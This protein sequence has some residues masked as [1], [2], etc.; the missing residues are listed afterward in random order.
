MSMSAGVRILAVDDEDYM[1]DLYRVALDD[2]KPDSSARALD[3]LISLYEGE[4][5]EEGTGPTDPAT[6]GYR[7]DHASQGMEGYQRVLEARQQG[8]PYAVVLL[9]IQMP[10]G[11]DGVETA[12]KIRQ[13]DPQVR[14]LLVTAFTYY[15]YQQIQQ[16]LGT[17][18][19]LINKPFKGEALTRLVELEVDKWRAARSV[20]QAQRTL[21]EAEGELDQ[22]LSR[23]RKIQSRVSA[24]V[25]ADSELLLQKAQYELILDSIQEGVLV[26]DRTG[27]VEY[28]NPG[29]GRM[30]GKAV[31]DL[32]GQPLAQLFVEGKG[33]QTAEPTLGQ[34]GRVQQFLQQ[35]AI[36]QPPLL[37]SWID[38]SLVAVLRINARGKVVQSNAAMQALSGWTV[39]QLEGNPIDL[40]P[41]DIREQ[42]AQM[43]QQFIQQGEARRMGG[44]SGLFEIHTRTRK[45]RRVMI[46]LIPLQYEG[47][48]QVVVVLHDPDEQ[49]QWRLFQL[50]PFGR[51]FSEDEQT[52]FSTSMAMHHHN[53]ELIPVHVTGAPLYHCEGDRQQFF[54]VVLMLHNAASILHAEEQQRLQQAKDR[55]LSTVSHELR[56]PLTGIIGNGE[57][58][59][60][61]PLQSQQQQFVQ[62]IL[63]SGQQMLGAVNQMIQYAELNSGELELQQQSFIPQRLLESLVDDLQPRLQEKGVALELVPGPDCDRPAL[64][65]MERIRQILSILLD[66]AIKVTDSGSIRLEGSCDQE[67]QRLQ[68]RVIDSGCGIALADQ[69]RIFLPFEQLDDSLSRSHMG[70]GLGLY[71]ARELSKRMQG[72]LQ[73]ES[74]PGRGSQFVLTLPWQQPDTADQPV[75]PIEA[76][77]NRFQGEVLVVEDTPEMQ[78]L[79]RKILESAGLSVS[80]A[81]HGEEAVQLGLQYSY[82]LI[83]M[84]MQM[85]IMD[86]IEAT[87]TL[88][89]LGVTTPIVALT[90]N[91]VQSNRD[92]FFEAG[93]NDF[94]G[95]PVVRD[96][97]F[98]TLSN[99]LLSGGEQVETAPQSLEIDPQL[100]QLFVER[101]VELQQQLEQALQHTQWK[102]LRLIA[103][104]LKGSGSSFGF[105]EVTRLGA[106]VCNA[107]DQEQ[108]EQAE[109]QGG[110]LN[111]ALV[112]IIRAEGV[113]ANRERG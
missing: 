102:D 113:V 99:Y 84:D 67:Q 106:E 2:E 88:R 43:M 56:T 25:V 70:L 18:F 8:D 80:V 103:H 23:N 14:I 21:L 79:V 71:I 111:D 61:E 15:N 36:E 110:V 42:H 49:Q 97:L 40:L 54:G 7:M 24:E 5:T 109:V 55:F 107:I 28:C 85:P 63:H 94:L 38:S 64:G 100:R 91:V 62:Q 81:N 75:A 98:R 39:R 32:V 11:W 13:V 12:Q 74:T 105:E 31:T 17:D 48:R 10:P 69:E 66:N 82:D 35:V 112:E 83:L 27:G 46:G 6:S 104:N 59:Q 58:L 29:M 73:L 50:T 57:L 65:D 16:K 78:L 95:K 51:L 30:L 87:E 89:S 68:L 101:V 33:G 77:P 86:G 60:Q 34:T 90:A 47:E 92:R 22:H 4:A 52:E 9:D 37:Q 45:I 76:V 93:C 1:H 72:V 44:G 26:V 20:E 96:Q 19:A 53:G 3:D 108:H 41:P